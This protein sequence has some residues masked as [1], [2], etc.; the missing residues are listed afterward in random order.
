M[1]PSIPRSHLRQASRSPLSTTSSS[2]SNVSRG[3]AKRKADNKDELMADMRTVLA[4]LVAVLKAD[5]KMP[6]SIAVER[7]MHTD[8][9]VLDE[10]G[11]WDL[12]RVMRADPS[13]VEL[14][15]VIFAYPERRRS[16]VQ[17][18]DKWTQM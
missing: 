6:F 1:T 14:Y 16:W 9:D 12:V 13:A 5:P 10:A 4:E 18:R 11:F 17:D 7:L 15:N 3:Y 8:R 2:T